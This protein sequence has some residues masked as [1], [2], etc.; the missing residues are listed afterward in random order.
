MRPP[1]N[2]V[3]NEKRRGSRSLTRRKLI[4]E[5]KREKKSA[6]E[7]EKSLSEREETQGSSHGSQ[8]KNFRKRNRPQHT[9]PNRYQ[10]RWKPVTG[11]DVFF[12]I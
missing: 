2:N 7:T 4:F 8:G 9:M 12:R 3:L 6:R 10:V 1:R 5:G 11:G